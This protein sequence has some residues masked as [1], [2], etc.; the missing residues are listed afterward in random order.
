MRHKAPRR[1]D[2]DVNNQK[3]LLDR[4]GW[5]EKDVVYV[6]PSLE[7]SRR[8][9]F[10]GGWAGLVCVCLSPWVLVAADS[11]AKCGMRV[12]RTGG[13]QLSYI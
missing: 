13:A 12:A 11:E 6:A 7:D 4:W 5:I 10:F 3:Y 2:G 8:A 9:A 1:T